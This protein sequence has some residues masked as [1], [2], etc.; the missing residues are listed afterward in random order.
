M[1]FRDGVIFDKGLNQKLQEET[2]ELAQLILYLQN[3]KRKCTKLSNIR[4]WDRCIDEAI[5]VLDEVVGVKVYKTKTSQGY[6]LYVKNDLK[7]QHDTADENHCYSDEDKAKYGLLIAILMF[8]YMMH[9]PGSPDYT[10]SESLLK[11]FLQEM[12]I[13]ENSCFGN[14]TDLNKLLGATY[15]AEFISQGWLAFTKGT[16]ENGCDTVAYEWG[17]RAKSV[18][19][20]MTILRTYCTMD[21]SAPHHWRLHYQEA[22][23]A[24]ARDD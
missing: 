3:R 11:R 20:P 12:G 8:I 18:I 13:T 15:T 24:V 17:P 2:A 16:D 23:N 21:G 14:Q 5:D 22:Q 6:Q 4:I 10:V 7:I 1:R 9:R 19:D